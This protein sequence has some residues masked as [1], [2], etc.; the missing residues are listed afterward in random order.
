M[1]VKVELSIY[2]L[3]RQICESLSGSVVLINIRKLYMGATI[4]GC[5]QDCFP[6]HSLK[7][8]LWNNCDRKHELQKGNTVFGVFW[9]MAFSSW[10]E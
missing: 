9:L 1:N 5:C 7:D 4:K 6:A 10:G 3:T 8:I 2:K